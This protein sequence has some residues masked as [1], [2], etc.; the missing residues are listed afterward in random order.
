[1]SLCLQ[2]FLFF[3]QFFYQNRLKCQ[4]FSIENKKKQILEIR[5]WNTSY[6][7]TKKICWGYVTLMIQYLTRVSKC[8]HIY[9]GGFFFWL[10]RHISCK[11]KPSQYLLYILYGTLFSSLCHKQHNVS[12]SI[13]CE[14]F[15]YCIPFCTITRST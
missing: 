1:M 8:H 13:L 15:G 10:L 4:L 2:I 11:Q 3:L 5:K 12:F 6:Y 14:F 9:N 7:K